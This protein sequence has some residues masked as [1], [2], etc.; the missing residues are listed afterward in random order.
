[1][2]TSQEQKVLVGLSWSLT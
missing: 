2:S 1:V